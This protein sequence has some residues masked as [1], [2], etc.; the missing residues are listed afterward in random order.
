MRSFAF[1]MCAVAYM[2]DVLKV[3][4]KITRKIEEN[5]CHAFYITWSLTVEFQPKFKLVRISQ[6]A[7]KLTVMLII[8]LAH[9]QGAL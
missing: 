5:K 1:L 3:F 7:F 6:G 8:A 4:A 2:I 9:H